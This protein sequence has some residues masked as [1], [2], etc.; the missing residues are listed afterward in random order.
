M[1]SWWF[2][3]GLEAHVD[4]SL[5]LPQTDKHLLFFYFFANFRTGGDCART[6]CSGNSRSSPASR[7]KLKHFSY[8]RVTVPST[9]TRVKVPQRTKY[10]PVWQHD[11][12]KNGI[13]F[14]CQNAQSDKLS[15]LKLKWTQFSVDHKTSVLNFV[16][17]RPKTHVKYKDIT[18]LPPPPFLSH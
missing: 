8:R 16:N 11:P 5:Y 3:W 10:S 6:Q 17:V 14:E 12:R 9:R 15:I 4:F 1:H 2:C 18:H 7:F 13:I